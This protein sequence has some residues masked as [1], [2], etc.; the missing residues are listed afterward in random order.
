LAQQNN[1]IIVIQS[2]FSENPGYLKLKG[3]KEDIKGKKQWLKRDGFTSQ[4]NIRNP[5]PPSH[6]LEAKAVSFVA[7]SVVLATQSVALSVLLA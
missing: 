3:R 4:Y 6:L 1:N 2:G 5:F 7:L